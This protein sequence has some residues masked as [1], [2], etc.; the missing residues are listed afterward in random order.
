MDTWIFKFLVICFQM[1]TFLRVE[2]FIRNRRLDASDARVNVT[3]FAQ[4]FHA[5]R[6]ASWHYF[7]MN[8][9]SQL[10]F[11]TQDWQCPCSMHFEQV[12]H[13]FSPLPPVTMPLPRADLALLKTQ[14][15]QDRMTLFSPVVITFSL[16]TH[17][18][19]V[20]LKIPTS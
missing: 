14:L 2:F 16:L 8:R 17:F 3:R 11:Q 13:S 18:P 5:R 10:F 12:T 9:C 6:I 1:L 20:S 15:L 19:S 7:D 4:G